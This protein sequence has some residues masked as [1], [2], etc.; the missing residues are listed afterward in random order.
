MAT[1]F[2]EFPRPEME[3]E[4]RGPRL[5]LWL[6][7]GFVILVVFLAGVWYWFFLTEGAQG[8]SEDQRRMTD[9]VLQLDNMS[10]DLVT[11]RQNLI[12]LERRV[13]RQEEQLEA[14]LIQ[15]MKK[16]DQKLAALRHEIEKR[17]QRLIHR[18]NFL[19]R[20][21]EETQGGV[22][23][24]DAE[25]LL[26]VAVQ[27]L[28]LLGDV[29]S[30]LKAMEAADQILRQ[31]EGDPAILK[32]REALAQEIAA[33]QTVEVPD[34]VEITARL[35][36][37]QKQAAELPLTYPAPWQKFEAQQESQP[38]QD[39]LEQ[40]KR[41]L[42]VQRQRLDR[43]VEGVLTKEQAEAIRQVLQ[44]KLES[45]K[46]AAFRGEA[47]L[48]RRFLEEAELWIKAYFNTRSSNV[49]AF[50][51]E[52]DRLQ[53]E[54]VAPEIPEIGRAHILLQKLPQLRLELERG[55]ENPPAQSQ[56]VLQPS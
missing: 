45:A 13:G 37:L 27:K 6:L 18:M 8:A 17:D 31:M 24:A 3:E 26:S 40:W 43:P 23:I 10:R 39:T 14:Q 19:E 15:Y 36:R 5:G 56:E 46:L 32:V 1:P 44:L 51:S 53:R 50:L 25:Y 30:A 35:S 12:Q 28:Q 9:V 2:D 41:I 47:D 55:Q 22:M 7:M 42:T 29:K 54:P 20:F 52:L 38:P 4:E 33:L 49:V 21:L 48:Y 16:F 11:L 34:L